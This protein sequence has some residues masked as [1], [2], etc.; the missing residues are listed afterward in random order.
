MVARSLCGDLGFSGRREDAKKI[1]KKNRE[2]GN[3][4]KLAVV[5]VRVVQPLVFLRKKTFKR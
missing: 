1:K 2:E 5:I 4:T 3:V